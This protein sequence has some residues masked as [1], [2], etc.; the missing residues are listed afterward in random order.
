M[1]KFIHTA[2]L[3][4]DSPFE[5]L[6]D[7]LARQRRDEQREL[8][9]RIVSLAEDERVDLILL[10]GDLLDSDS[11]YF[12]TA[13]LFEQVFPQTRAK[14]FIAPGNHD[15]YTRISPWARLNL[16]GNVH[17][18]RNNAIECVELPELGARIYGAG[19]EQKFAPPLLRGF[20]ANRTDG[21]INLMVMHGD[22]NNERSPYNPIAERDVAASGLDYI[23]L[24]HVHLASGLQKAGET[25]YAYPGCPEG[26]GFDERGEKTVLVAEVKPGVCETRSVSLGTR[27]YE[28][29][30]ADIAGLPSVLSPGTE[31]DIYRIILKGERDT[32]PDLN[33]L[34]GQLSPLFFSLQLRDATCPRRDLWEWADEDTL[35]GLFIR[36]LRRLF[37]EAAGEG[38]K[39]QILSALRFGLAAIDGMEDQ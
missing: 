29:L 11:A 25:Y 33:A 22:L 27:R 23:A 2:D 6:G 32:P 10:A 19:F 15:P 38:A 4:L 35:R 5:A 30:E 12:E 34:R 37:D 39:S 28:I 14:I 24:G 26:R 3:H 31:R 16:T 13:R 1:I 7:E 21:A 8:L 20:S 9:T 18:F 17:I 36:R